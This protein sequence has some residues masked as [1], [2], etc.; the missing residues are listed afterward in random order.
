METPVCKSGACN[1]QGSFQPP[2][3]NIKFKVHNNKN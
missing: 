1:Y 2:V 3:E